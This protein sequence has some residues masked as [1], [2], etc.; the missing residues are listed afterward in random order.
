MIHPSGKRATTKRESK[1]V[2]WLTRSTGKEKSFDLD[3]DDSGATSSGGDSK[4]TIRQATIVQK[5]KRRVEERLRRIKLKRDSTNEE[6]NVS[7]APSRKS[8][9]ENIATENVKI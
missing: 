7:G 8:S 9:L 5:A 4:R 6:Y 2:S 1:L 3:L